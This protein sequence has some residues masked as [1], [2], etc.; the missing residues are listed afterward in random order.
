MFSQ[1]KG[2]QQWE[3]RNRANNLRFIARNGLSNRAGSEEQGPD[4]T[5]IKLEKTS[6]QTDGT[7]NTELNPI[8]VPQVGFLNYSKQKDKKR[9]IFLYIE[10]I[11]DQ[12][13]AE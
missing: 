12:S 13:R 8:K 5:D 3:S 7:N 1:S 2:A 10:I 6:K 9:L 11:E 4:S